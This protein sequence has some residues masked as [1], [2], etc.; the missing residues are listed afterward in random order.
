MNLSSYISLKTPSRH[1]MRGL[2]LDSKG[3]WTQDAGASGGAPPLVWHWLGEFRLWPVLGP[4][5]EASGPPVWR[6]PTESTK[7]PGECLQLLRCVQEQIAQGQGRC[8]RRSKDKSQGTKDS[9]Q[10]PF[11]TEG[12]NFLTPRASD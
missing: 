6:S 11:Q 1:E 5:T 8:S 12:R 3:N 4:Q 10:Y 2:R 9:R 7:G